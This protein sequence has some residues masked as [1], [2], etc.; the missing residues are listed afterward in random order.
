MISR[1]IRPAVPARCIWPGGRR[2]SGRS[3]PVVLA[4]A[5]TH[6]PK[7]SMQQQAVATASATLRPVVMGPGS[8]LGSASLV[9]DD[10]DCI[11]DLSVGNPGESAADKVRPTEHSRVPPSH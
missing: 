8:A 9:Q 5:R 3:N 10:S 1:H 6:Y 11:T 2:P 7:C 4:K